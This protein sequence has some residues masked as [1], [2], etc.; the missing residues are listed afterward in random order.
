VRSRSF[1]AALFQTDAALDTETFLGFRLEGGL[2]AVAD[3]S[4]HA[5]GSRSGDTTVPYIMVRD[6]EAA[7]AHVANVEGVCALDRQI[8]TEGS[9]RL[10]KFRD[11]DGNAIEYFSVQVAQQ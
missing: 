2:F 6:I 3:K 8:T 9:I 1:Y 7:Y 10:F 4:T 5:P 11:P